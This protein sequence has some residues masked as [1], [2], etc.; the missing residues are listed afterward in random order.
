MKTFYELIGE[1][2]KDLSPMQMAI[3]AVLVFIIALIM[4]RLSGR[5]AF[6]MHSPFDIVSSI[7]LGAILS[8]SVIGGCPF[9]SPI[10]GSIAIVGLHWI[11]A[12]VST[13]NDKFGMVVK[14]KAKLL[15]EDGKLFRK[16]MLAGFISQKDLEEAMRKENIDSLGK[17]KSASMERDGTISIVKK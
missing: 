16:N 4:I 14:G 9:F 5:R 8:R 15:Y 10:A 6:G 1:N 7:L 3:R 13:H 12:R 17:V 2:E 11:I